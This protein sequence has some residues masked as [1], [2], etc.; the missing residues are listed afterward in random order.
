MAHLIHFIKRTK[1]AAKFLSSP[2]EP[3]QH[4]NGIE[5]FLGYQNASR[6]KE[7]FFKK[8]IINFIFRS[9]EI[10]NQKCYN[11]IG[12]CVIGV[13]MIEMSEIYY[14]LMMF[15]IALIKGKIID[16][17][18]RDHQS[19]AMLRWSLTELKV[20]CEIFVINFHFSIKFL[21]RNAGKK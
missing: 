11:F 5:R 18:F 1:E 10:V 3:T 7:R 9:H 6:T 14:P 17:S 8:I 13:I 4:N 19:G 15:C 2:I 20:L 12:G 21:I 16:L